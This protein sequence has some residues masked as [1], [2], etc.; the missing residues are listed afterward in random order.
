[1][2]DNNLL[3]RKLIIKSMERKILIFA[4][5]FLIIALMSYNV[6]AFQYWQVKYIQLNDTRINTNYGLVSYTNE[7][8]GNPTLE[9]LVGIG[10]IFPLINVG[11]MSFSDTIE[12]A[13][14]LEVKIKYS[15]Y[16]DDWNTANPQYLVNY[17]NLQIKYQPY[18]SILFNNTIIQPTIVFSQNFTTSIDNGEYF[19]R[20]KKGDSVY[21]RFNCYFENNALIEAPADFVIVT[22]TENCQECQYYNW[23]KM[24]KT[25]N[26]ANS[27][28][29][30][31]SSILTYIVKFFN[32]NFEIIVALFYV[33][34]IIAVIF[35]IGLIFYGLL[36]LYKAIT[37]WHK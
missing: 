1:M 15:T 30:Y 22:P 4:F 16:V 32:M 7:V 6:S 24:E 21:V 36:Y 2:K 17:C 35:I 19:V 9:S 28:A 12:G 3:I 5:A 34:L 14:P 10:N 8:T 26:K 37:K 23:N 27:N 13:T 29:D 18:Y 33:F 20:L 25:L 31:K 11:T